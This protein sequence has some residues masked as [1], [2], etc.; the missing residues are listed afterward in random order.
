MSANIPL[1]VNEP[2]LHYAPGSPERAALQAAIKELG[3]VV[4]DIPV[5][6]NGRE[7]REGATVRVTSPQKHAHHLATTH[8]AS[9][10]LLNEA[11]RGAVTVQKDWENW[12]FADRAA[13]FLK[14]ADLLAGPWRQRINAATLL[15]QGKTPHQAEIDSACELIDFLRF[16]VHF[17]E[18]ILAEQ[19]PGPRIHSGLP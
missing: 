14:A 10:E 17:A 16:N 1:P 6:V 15:G 11:I 8:L 18:K 12:S 2:V 9:T 13:V 19:P 7:Y 3:S 4:T 5:V